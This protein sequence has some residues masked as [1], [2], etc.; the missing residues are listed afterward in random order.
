[1]ATPTS[2]W[3]PRRPADADVAKAV[4]KLNENQREF[5]EERAAILQFDAGMP[6]AQAER[7]ALRLTHVHFNLRA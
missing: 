1:M 2:A 7:E 5:F 4:A 6:I 3:H